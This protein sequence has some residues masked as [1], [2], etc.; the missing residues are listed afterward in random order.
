MSSL[1][2]RDRSGSS[3]PVAHT[4]RPR[5][6]HLRMDSQAPADT[7]VSKVLNRGGERRRPA[8]CSG[9]AAVG[10]AARSTV[11]TRGIGHAGITGHIGDPRVARTTTSPHGQPFL[12]FPKVL[13]VQGARRHRGHDT[14]GNSRRRF[15]QL[16]TRTNLLGGA[17]CMG[18]EQSSRIQWPHPGN[19]P[20]MAD[21]RLC[22]ATV[23]PALRSLLIGAIITGL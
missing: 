3:S 13:H 6:F 8:A 23:G 17:T 21:C 9:Y 12:R 1:V 5:P 4:S 16:P 7:S 15:V 19:R 20:S 11:F 22:C 10:E 18:S 14:S 2:A